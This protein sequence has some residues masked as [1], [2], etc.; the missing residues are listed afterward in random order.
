MDNNNLRNRL[1][2]HKTDYNPAAWNKMN[3]LLNSTPIPLKSPLFP[4]RL[5]LPGVIFLSLS[6]VVA[7]LYFS[8]QSPFKNNITVNPS[9]TVLFDQAKDSNTNDH[10][11]L[12]TSPINQATNSPSQIDNSLDQVSSASPILENE[13]HD[14]RDAFNVSSDISREAE[15]MSS[16]INKELGTKL[17]NSVN[18]VSNNRKS[19]SN[20][21]EDKSRSGNLSALESIASSTLPVS[22]M[23]TH[24]D[25]DISIHTE[26]L[27]SIQNQNNEI[28]SAN[29][30]H[31][32]SKLRLTPDVS[33]NDGESAIAFQNATS[34]H[35][36]SEMQTQFLVPS[37]VSMFHREFEYP[38]LVIKHDENHVYIPPFK[39]AYSNFWLQFTA[40]QTDFLA[41]KGI[42]AGIGINYRI[43]RRWEMTTELAYYNVR[44]ESELPNKPELF[45]DQMNLNLSV[46]FNVIRY[47]KHALGLEVIS[48][49]TSVSAQNVVPSLDYQVHDKS[50]EGIHYGLGGV[51]S[52]DINRNWRFYI[53]YNEVHFIETLNGFSVS[54]AK[55]L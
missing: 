28:H 22:S 54:L 18:P 5:L 26:S 17:S 8:P 32:D 7:F 40:G 44:R 47:K 9:Q 34:N 24:Y 30:S 29:S 37:K 13:M 19:N 4:K 31:I 39:G 20:S 27:Q 11:N 1:N 6:L 12:A 46:Q 38:D 10:I 42:K 21:I 51:Y 16:V 25:K 23:E 43:S 2:N 48:G 45:A 33:K 50:G 3:D 52:Y 55:Q 35:L 41:V 53:K 14:T 36:S 49:L 15:N